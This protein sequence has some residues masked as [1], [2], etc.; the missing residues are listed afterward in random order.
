VKKRRLVS[1][2]DLP[3][4]LID[5]VL[6]SEDRRFFSPQWRRPDPDPE[7]SDDR[8]PLRRKRQGASTLTQQFV[9]QFF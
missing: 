1:Y 9:K 7:G 2:Q 3:R 4:A 6:A 8:Y 5:A